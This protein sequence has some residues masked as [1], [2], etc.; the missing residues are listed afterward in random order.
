MPDAASC[1]AM[2]LVVHWA[3]RGPVRTNDVVNGTTWESGTGEREGNK[4]LC[5][6]STQLSGEDKHRQ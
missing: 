4:D 6:R 3:P 5:S 1:R 2:L